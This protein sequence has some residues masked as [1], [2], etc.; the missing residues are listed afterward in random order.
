[1]MNGI[2]FATSHG[3][4]PRSRN[5]QE[6]MVN[7]LIW[8]IALQSQR[9]SGTRS[10]RYFVSISCNKIA[11]KMTSEDSEFLQFDF[12]K[13]LTEEIDTKKINCVSHD[14]CIYDTFWWVGIV[15]K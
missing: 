10:S 8:R 13:P 6:E 15:T 12:D 3:K 9:P 7:L 4:S 5:G 1:M 14:S 11:H 2:L